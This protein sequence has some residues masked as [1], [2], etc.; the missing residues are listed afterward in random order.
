MS[1]FFL[2]YYV[3]P[4]PSAIKSV[5]YRSQGI[6]IEVKMIKEKDKDHKKFIEELKVDI[7]NYSE[8]KELKHLILFTYDSYKKTTDDNHLLG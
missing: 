5:T 4:I 1:A 8:W 3:L 6:M 7:I 2:I